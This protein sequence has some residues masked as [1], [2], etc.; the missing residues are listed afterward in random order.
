MDNF[1]S[2]FQN[3]RQQLENELLQSNRR[4]QSNNENIENDPRF[5]NNI[6][7]IV[8]D[9]IG[10]VRLNQELMSIFN[11]NMLTIIEIIRTEQNRVE[12]ERRT[13]EDAIRQHEIRANIF[14]PR[15]TRYRAPDTNTRS[16]NNRPF[17]SQLNQTYRAPTLFGVSDVS[18]NLRSNIP[19][20]ITSN[21]I[22]NLTPRNRNNQLDARHFFGGLGPELRDVVIHPSNSEIERATTTYTFTRDMV[23]FNHRCYITMED[24]EEGDQ[25]REIRHCRHTFKNDALLNWF[26]EHVRCP[27]C[28]FDIR[29]YQPGVNEM[30]EGLLGSRHSS[31]NSLNSSSESIGGNSSGPS[32]PLNQENNT[33]E[34]FTNTDSA[35]LNSFM[36]ESLAQDVSNGINDILEN[37]VNDISNNGINTSSNLRYSLSVPIIY[38]EFFDSSNNLSFNNIQFNNSP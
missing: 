26:Q 23:T 5:L 13:R 18:R 31:R 34:N 16:Y 6:T 11:L 7:S 29:D 17:Q 1:E 33:T 15:Y 24:F 19:S 37:L 3:V 22:G 21:F 28:R 32:S 36:A 25:L 14:E 30:E 20:V 4:N 12:R 38:H 2:I 27:V 8:N 10:V 9:Y 35:D